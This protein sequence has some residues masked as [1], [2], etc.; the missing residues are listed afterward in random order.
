MN[1]TIVIY[2]ARRFLKARRIM[3]LNYIFN[4]TCYIII[5]IVVLKGFIVEQRIVIDTASAEDYIDR[6][7]VLVT[8]FVLKRSV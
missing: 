2:H 4:N 6:I 8:Q 3:W 1:R 5:V 7:N